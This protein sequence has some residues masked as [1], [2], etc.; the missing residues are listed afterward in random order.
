MNLHA[1]ILKELTA[2][3]VA[4]RLGVFVGLRVARNTDTQAV[5]RTVVLIVAPVVCSKG[6]CLLF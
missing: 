2:F 3:H 5:C 1:R 4:S 6:H